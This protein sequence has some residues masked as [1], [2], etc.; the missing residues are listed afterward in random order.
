MNG[1]YSKFAQAQSSSIIEIDSAGIDF[2]TF[3]TMNLGGGVTGG[4]Y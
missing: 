1:E 2:S 4:V 3:Q